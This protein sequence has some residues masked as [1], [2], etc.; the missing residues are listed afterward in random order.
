MKNVYIVNADTMYEGSDPIK[1]FMSK[2]AAEQFRDK[3]IAHS[4][5]KPPQPESIQGHHW[6]EED[7]DKWYLKHSRWK[8]KHPAGED[9][10]SCDF[11]ILTLPLV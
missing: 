10:S 8:K 7:Y 1:A 2:P 3:C 11:S 6:N 4:A 9:F 5:K